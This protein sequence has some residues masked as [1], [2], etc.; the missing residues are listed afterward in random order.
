MVFLKKRKRLADRSAGIGRTLRRRRIRKT[1][2]QRNHS[3]HCSPH[4]DLR[5]AKPWVQGF[6]A[7]SGPAS[8]MHHRGGRRQVNVF[9]IDAF[10]TS[11]GYPAGHTG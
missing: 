10:E 8:W 4:A 9:E 2:V 7:L 5:P 3:Q 6:K 1:N 11:R